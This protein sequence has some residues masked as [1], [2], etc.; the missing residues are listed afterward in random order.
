M[1]DLRF[2]IG[3]V[4]AIALLIVAV[5]G[6][7]A[8]VQVAHYRSATADDPWRTLAFPDPT[9]WAFL[10]DR[11]RPVAKAEVTEGPQAG[12]TATAP[13]PK[14][15]GT[16]TVAKT[17]DRVVPQEAEAARAAEPML[18]PPPATV[19]AALLTASAEVTEPDL[20]PTELVP[21]E[22]APTE[23]EPVDV[24]AAIPESKALPIWP[25]ELA[26]AIE[27]PADDDEALEP[28]ERVRTLPA[29]PT[30]GHGFVPPEHPTALRPPEPSKPAVK[31]PPKKKVARSR[32]RPPP[33]SP[34]LANTGYPLFGFDKFGP[35]NK[36]SYDKKWTVE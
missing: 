28:S 2:A 11:S 6:L 5:F 21:T 29:F 24:V 13:D 22:L 12:L 34:P 7:A 10:A 23:H 26:P 3:A 8:T 4:L 15:M 16:T 25:A 35:D 31:K 27:R 9:D 1:P 19:P 30:A 17:S 18:D 32:S 20:A 14:I 33:A 36:T